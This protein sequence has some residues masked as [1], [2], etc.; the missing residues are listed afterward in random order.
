MK[1]I[2]ICTKES[3]R[4]TLI[5]CLPEKRWNA[6]TCCLSEIDQA[7]ED[8]SPDF[9]IIQ[10]PFPAC[11]LRMPLLRLYKRNLHPYIILFESK[12]IL[13]Y[14]VS[15]IFEKK[16]PNLKNDASFLLNLL[17]NLLPE[18]GYPYEEIEEYTN[19]RRIYFMGQKIARA[20]FLR[21]AINGISDSVFQE[22]LK[23]FQV[24]LHPKGH[25]LLVLKGMDPDFFNDYRNNHCIYYLLENQQRQQVYD[26]LNK[27]S[28]GE[29]VYTSSKH[30][31]CLLFNDFP[32][33][34]LLEKQKKMEEFLNE[35][36][37]V[38]NDGQ[39][40]H[41]LS[42]YI[43]SPDQINDAYAD[44]M[45][46]RQYKLF[47]QSDK[48]LRT[49]DFK[50]NFRTKQASPST[51][52][53]ALKIIQGFDASD[54]IDNLKSQLMKI[55]LELKKSIDLNAFHYCCSV[56][57]IYY[58]NFCRRY[59]LNYDSFHLSITT[60]WTLSI[61]DIRDV[62][63]EK[64]R[65]AY[66]EALSQNQ[67]DDPTITRIISYVKTYYNKPITL[68]DIASH[69]DMNPSYISR[70]FSQCTGMTLTDYVKRLRMEN[71]KE[72]FSTSKIT[73]KEAAATVG[74][75]DAHLFSKEF[76]RYT[77]M[78]PTEYLKPNHGKNTIQNHKE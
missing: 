6:R 69:V 36:Y 37:H 44:C 35:L 43:S 17:F 29:I 21:D 34:S 47:F 1:R 38:T 10:L 55:F 23:R 64:F 60:N 50:N 19:D 20:E 42:G 57:D 48:Y 68:S 9:L 49:I 45:I 31:E 22:N 25:Y 63:M 77:G 26:V 61:E 58:E 41:F 2:L 46:L 67:Y 51:L 71:A 70:K 28:G 18:C 52:S 62:Y 30:T 54:N 78:T 40:A 33:R 4:N 5:E 39:T 76:K 16:R 8:F 12:R 13:S 15:N 24:N 7:A 56:L 73:V 27:Y 66:Q 32:Q 72:L 14:A 65:K 3:V 53:S 11:S 74:Y 59:G 75:A